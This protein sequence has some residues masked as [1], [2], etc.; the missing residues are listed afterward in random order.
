MTPS[1]VRQLKPGTV[2]LVSHRQKPGNG[3]TPRV[4][5]IYKGLEHRGV[6]PCAVFTAKVAKDVSAT[7]DES[8]GTIALSGKR[9][10]RTEISIPHYDIQVADPT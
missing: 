4:R 3:K 5:R 2:Y 1:E 10:P 6:V 9:L 7:Y 8:K